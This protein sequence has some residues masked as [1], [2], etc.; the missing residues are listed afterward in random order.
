M[1][2]LPAHPVSRSGRQA[3]RAREPGTPSTELCSCLQSPGS[4]PGVCQRL[5]RERLFGHA[6]EHCM[7]VDWG[8][9]VTHP[10]GNGL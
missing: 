5:I 3:E 7:A 4:Y 9:A 6:V 8:G 2:A 10:H 1:G